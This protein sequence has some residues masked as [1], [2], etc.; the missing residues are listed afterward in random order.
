ME[1]TPGREAKRGRTSFR[2]NPVGGWPLDR[3]LVGVGTLRTMR[4]L[5]HQD[6]RWS[7]G[8]CRAWDLALWT[9]V[10]PQ[11]ASK[12]MKRLARE[13]L[14]RTFPS[15]VR[16]RAPTYRLIRSHPLTPP[17]AHLFEVERQTVE[18]RG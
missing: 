18:D 3:L 13:K 6:E 14:V 16:G 5:F 1:R 17:L 10:T 11:G 9:R 8:S 2:L 4:E 12:S 15:R 7:G